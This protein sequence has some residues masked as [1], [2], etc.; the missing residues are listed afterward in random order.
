MRSILKRESNWTENGPTEKQITEELNIA[1]NQ[2]AYFQKVPDRTVKSV[3]LE[4]RFVDHYYEL[5]APQ[6]LE[7]T[8][9]HSGAILAQKVFDKIN[10]D[11][12]ISLV[13][14]LLNN[15]GT[16]KIGCPEHVFDV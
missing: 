16:H 3:S 13:T 1:R 7:L 14:G 11:N 10:T 12:V 9:L 5:L 6:I 2:L 4:R 15:P 8:T